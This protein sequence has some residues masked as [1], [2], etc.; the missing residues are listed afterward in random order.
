V[1]LGLLSEPPTRRRRARGHPASCAGKLPGRLTTRSGLAWH[2]VDDRGSRSR[3]LLADSIGAVD[4]RHRSAPP[5]R[6]P[7]R[8]G[9]QPASDG[10]PLL[11]SFTQFR[12]RQPPHI[13]FVRS[14]GRRVFLPAAQS[15]SSPGL[16]DNTGGRRAL[17][18]HSADVPLVALVWR[19]DP[20][21]GRQ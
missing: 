12:R 20:T 17:A 10:R 5:R 11:I 4:R 7:D 2:A 9:S 3:S 6:V 1:A 14:A 8:A 18:V 13:P 19:P 21:A 15:D 16:L